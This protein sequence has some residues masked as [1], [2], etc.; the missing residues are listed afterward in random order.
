MQ[1]IV[2]HKNA[3]VAKYQCRSNGSFDKLL[4]VYDENLLPDKTQKTE[5][6]LQRW[7]ILRMPSGLRKNFAPLKE[8]YGQEHF[9][10]SN[11]RSLFDCYWI[12]D[13][14]D[15]ETTWDAINPYTTWDPSSDSIYMSIYKPADFEGFDESSPNLTIPGAAPLIWYEFDDCLGLI[16]ENAQKDMSEYKKAKELGIHVMAQRSYKILSGRVFTFRKS[17]TNCDVERI[18][19]DSLYNSVEDPSKTKAENIKNC[20]EF[21]GIPNWKEFITEMI[22]FDNAC[23]NKNRELFD[24]GVLRDANSLECISFDL[25]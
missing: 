21:Y 9:I 1:K 14:S 16:N 19:F 24:I 10:S 15:T 18:S 12:K 13:A 7:M 17:L 11:M 5:I 25:L 2:M 22:E 20:C 8:F 4:N 3:P 6:A 23:G